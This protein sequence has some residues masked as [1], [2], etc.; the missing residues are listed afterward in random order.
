MPSSSGGK[1]VKFAP[2]DILLGE[3][4]ASARPAPG[5]GD[6]ELE[7]DLLEGGAGKKSKEVVTDGYDS[8]SSAGSE[9]GFG[10]GGGRKGKV[11]AAG[12]DGGAEGEDDDDMFGGEEEDGKANGES[13]GKGKSKEFLEMGDIEGQE[14]GKGEDGEDGAEAEEEDE[15][16]YLPDDDLANDDDAPRSRRSKASM[17][18]TLRFVSSLAPT[19]CQC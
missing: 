10:I 3:S 16:D 19:S 6:D 12:K 4:A 9:G 1:R 5:G 13:K 17:G 2:D 14:F 11:G 18:Y 8:D 15:E 7:G